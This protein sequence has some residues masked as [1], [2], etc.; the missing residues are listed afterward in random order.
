MPS[1][2]NIAVA[3]SGSIAAY[4]AVEVVRLLVARGVG[5]TP[6]MTRSA[7]QFLGKATLSGIAGARV[8]HDI[9]DDTYPGEVHVELARSVEL[10]L[11]VPA[12]ADMLSRLASGRADDVV[13]ALALCF[14][15]PLLLAPAMHSRMWAHP[16]TRRNVATLE[17]DGRVRWVGPTFG[18]LASGETGMG[19]LAEPEEI[20]GAVFRE[21]SPRDLAGV[22]IV[23]SAGPTIEDI[24]PVRFIGNRSS[25]KMGFAVAERAAQRGAVVTL[26][27]GPVALQ[28]PAGTHRIDVRSALE[29]RAALEQAMGADLSAADALVMSAAVADYRPREPSPT[30]MKKAEQSLSLSLVR[31]PDLLAEIGARRAAVGTSAPVLVGFA[32]E[33]VDPGELVAYATE[34]LRQKKVDMIVAN[35]A[36]DSFGKSTNTATFVLADAAHA[37][38]PMSKSDLADRILDKVRDLSAARGVRPC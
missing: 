20:V 32:V 30:K 38:A 22:R 9:F 34:K 13:T 35:L 10:L 7:A 21:L 2:R 3:V 28:T 5:V 23:V 37:L 29:M 14:E 4:K 6:L 19:R 15:G 24:D 17:A 11:V 36:G 31:N 16:A 27:T 25:G 12:T 8:I 33:T 26:V 1:G 18:A